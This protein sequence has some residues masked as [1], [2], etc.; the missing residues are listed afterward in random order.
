MY[1]EYLFQKISANNKI[2]ENIVSAV[3]WDEK[4]FLANEATWSSENYVLYVGDS[5]LAKETQM[6]MDVKYDEAGIRILGLGKKAV[7]YVEDKNLSEEE[8]F[9]KLNALY[10][11]YKEEIE[12]K[13]MSS[14]NKKHSNI[15]KA[16][17][18]GLVLFTPLSLVGVAG[19]AAVGLG[20]NKLLDSR[21]EKEQI[22][23]IQKLC[24]TT[25]FYHEFLPDFLEG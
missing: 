5:D 23:I 6:F 3:L 12:K 16:A 10:E 9:T 22:K 11:K 21:K 2:G 1:A 14:F 8:D 18:T 24:A 20:G 15:K 13:D 19:A 4:Q 7:L 17:L 25:M